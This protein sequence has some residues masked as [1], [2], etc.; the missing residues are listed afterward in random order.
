MSSSFVDRFQCVLFGVEMGEWKVLRVTLYG[1][2]PV[3]DVVVLGVSCLET[4]EW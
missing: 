1:I 2:V 4:T 3:L